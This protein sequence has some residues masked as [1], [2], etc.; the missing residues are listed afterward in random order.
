[1]EIKILKETQ[2]EL[3]FEIIGEDHTFSNALQNFLNNRNEVVLASYKI[4]HP[5]LS[6]PQIYVKTKDM[7]IPKGKEK[8]LPLV[9]V[10]GIGPKNVEKLKKAGIKTANALLK[11]DTEKISKKS[12]ISAKMLEKYQAGAGELNFAEESVVRSVVKSALKDFAKA[13]KK[14]SA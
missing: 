8:L 3:E 14:A 4:K 13:F 1:M 11:A 9:D 6:N 5:L 2:N 12:G 7:P 10:K